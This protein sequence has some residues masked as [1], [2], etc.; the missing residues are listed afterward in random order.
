MNNALSRCLLGLDHYKASKI[1]ALKKKGWSE[2]KIQRWLSEK[3]SLVE[4]RAAIN[5]TSNK[6]SEVESW[7]D[8]VIEVLTS[9]YA[10]KIGVLLH[11]YSGCE[12]TEIIELSG[13]IITKLE[14]IN[15]E[16]FLTMHEDHLYEFVK[17]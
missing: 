3:A 11:M 1:F 10:R 13:K 5:S 15:E 16:V 6:P 17:A 8:F 2:T 9:K 14:N 4:K 12:S 7:K